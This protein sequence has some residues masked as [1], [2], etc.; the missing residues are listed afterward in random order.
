MQTRSMTLTI[1]ILLGGIA[2]LVL[3]PLPGSSCR[4]ASLLVTLTC[5]TCFSSCIVSA[6]PPTFPMFTP[7]GVLAGT[8]LMRWWVKINLGGQ[9]TAPHAPAFRPALPVRPSPTFPMLTPRGIL[10]GTKLM[11]WWVVINLG[12][13]QTAPTSVEMTGGS[14]LRRYPPY[15]LPEGR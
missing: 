13:Q 11:G 6:T 3:P 12:E 9:Q 4:L 1:R 5:R 14:F 7:R 10:A 2:M 8:E 15:R